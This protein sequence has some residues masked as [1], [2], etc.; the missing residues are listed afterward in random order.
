ML[1]A[2]LHSAELLL[3]YGLGMSRRKV[4]GSLS[5]MPQNLIT[6]EDWSSRSS[7]AFFQSLEQEGLPFPD[8]DLPRARLSSKA[9]LFQRHIQDVSQILLEVL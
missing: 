3:L 4:V 8:N 5:L 1:I 6:I 2:S 7:G 9:K